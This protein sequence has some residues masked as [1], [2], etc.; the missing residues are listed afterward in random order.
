[1][2]YSELTR[3]RTVLFY[4]PKKDSPNIEAPPNVPK[5]FQIMPPDALLL[6]LQVL[7]TLFP[8]P[9]I[10][11]ILLKAQIRYGGKPTHVNGPSIADA[12]ATFFSIIPFLKESLELPENTFSENKKTLTATF[13]GKIII[14]TMYRFFQKSKSFLKSCFQKSFFSHRYV[15]LYFF[16]EKYFFRNIFI[17]NGCRQN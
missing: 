9:E 2:F 6:N 14:F 15:I 17:R 12:C 5:I 7:Q 8:R 11:G 13:I 4:P 3:D 1:M 10:C 16:A